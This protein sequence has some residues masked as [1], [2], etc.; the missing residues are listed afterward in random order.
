MVMIIGRGSPATKTIVA[1]ISGLIKQDGTGGKELELYT[2]SHTQPAGEF[3]D[4]IEMVTEELP[5]PK[6]RDRRFF[7]A[8]I[9]KD[10]EGEYKVNEITNMN[11]FL[12]SVDAV[13]DERSG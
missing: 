3:P 4:I 2:D 10:A 6:E 5:L 1:A 13:A 8:S 11:E 9:V 12:E 7:M